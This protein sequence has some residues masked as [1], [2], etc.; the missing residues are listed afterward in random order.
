MDVV[1][2][3]M[4]IHDAALKVTGRAA[5]AAD[6]T[7]PGMLHAALVF[8]AVPHGIVRSVDASRALALPG[9]VAVL[10]CFDTPQRR[11]NRFRNF[12]GMETIE[13][14]QVLSRHVRFI[15]DRVACV[16]AESA[17]LAREAAAL[18]AVEYDELPF[19][20]EIEEVLAGKNA[21]IHEEGAVYGAAELT[22]GD[23][24][25]VEACVTASA[26][27][28]LARLTHL[29][30]EP[31]VCIASYERGTGELTVW[32]PNQSIHGIRT[33]MADL[34]E[35]PYER[36]RVIKTTM[37]GSFGAKQEWMLEPVAIA[38][39]M[40]VGRPVKLVF[41]RAEVIPS[42]ICRGQLDAV[43][44]IGVTRDG[45]LQS[46]DMDV[47]LD[48]GAY[49]GNSKDYI[50]TIGG[51]LSRCYKVP[52]IHYTARAVC[53]NT[54]VS[55]AYRGWGAPEAYIILEHG[56]NMAARK[57]G[58]DP[59]ELRLK[60]A[61]LPGQTDEKMGQPY[62]E[63]RIRESIEL[64][65]ERFAWDRLRGENTAFNIRGERYRRGC[66][67]GC[68][69][70]GNGY[71]PRM[72]DFAGVEMR[73]TESGGVILNCTLHDHGCGT[74]T[75]MQMVAAQAL[76]IPPESIS[77][78]EGDTAYSPLDIGCYASRTTY[79]I[80][81]AV[82]DCA[83]KL[84]RKIAEGVAE[85]W[86]VPADTL[87]V[88]GGEVRSLRDSRSL[89]FE[90]A[91]T[92]IVR[93]L[94]REIWVQHQHVN[95][96]NPGVTGAHFAHV[97]VD[98]LTGMV[99]ILDYL[100]VHDIGKAINRE[101]CVAQ[102]QGAVAMGAGA[103]LTEHLH[104]HENGRPISSMKDYHLLNSTALP[105]IRV[106]LVEDGGTEGPYGAK[107]I[108]EVCHVPVAPAI[109]GAVNDALQSELCRLPLNP[110]AIVALMQERRKKQC[111]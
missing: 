18:V 109:I 14:E 19:A 20:T 81:R 53:T 95:T 3:S 50:A 8:S 92:R 99:E 35:L 4:P 1:G 22:V 33:V 38:A 2:T 105:N 31:H 111:G 108:G 23:I 89:R 76:G 24:A 46:I 68:G 39:S 102:I 97:Q 12:R 60:N 87:T 104:V 11:F 29:A 43:V 80:G 107:S 90:E 96:S 94:Q 6:M 93:E 110:D 59:L 67:I 25:R 84:K 51:K 30:M 66:G 42:T 70:H 73:L 16:I 83:E 86:E 45:M 103:A 65:R 54:P 98:T 63:I 48:A 26:G 62:G 79:V 27:S 57:I 61:A 72:Q 37:G 36:V 82:V 34:F 9:V 100:A 44:D 58:M 5:Y 91:S 32:S 106:E 85:L 41:T 88:E 15:G 71:F 69:G 10:D 47:T 75:A 55:G 56:M 13:Q 77:A 21:G 7:L 74:V 49:L 78:R 101:M 40:R 17:Q 28:H 52:Y 64:G